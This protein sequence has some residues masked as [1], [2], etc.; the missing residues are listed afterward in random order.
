[1]REIEKAVINEGIIGIIKR[2]SQL[3]I[4]IRSR[5]DNDVMEVKI[6]KYLHGYF[7]SRK[8][9]DSVVE[10]FYKYW[11]L[12]EYSDIIEGLKK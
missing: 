12:S 1:M 5:W 10:H 6:N 11:F 8:G 7:Y 3:K 4:Y 2:N 9:N